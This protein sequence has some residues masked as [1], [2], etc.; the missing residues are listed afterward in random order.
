MNLFTTHAYNNIINHNYNND[1]N[2]VMLR[3]IRLS[4]FFRISVYK[5]KWNWITIALTSCVWTNRTKIASSLI[6]HVLVTKGWTSNKYGQQDLVSSSGMKI[7]LVEDEGVKVAPF[8]LEH[9]VLFW[10]PGGLTEKNINNSG[11]ELALHFKEQS[12]WDQQ[13]SSKSVLEV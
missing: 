3:I 8:V 6:L 12:C 7:L 1:N 2:N 13:E 5:Q 9:W 11:I 4:S 10:R